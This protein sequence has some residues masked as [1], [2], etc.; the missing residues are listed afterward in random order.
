MYVYHVS[1]MEF[2]LSVSLW[3]LFA[4]ERL[5]KEKEVMTKK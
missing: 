4:V 5:F 2:C 3:K 1:S